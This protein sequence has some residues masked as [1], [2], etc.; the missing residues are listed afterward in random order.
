MKNKVKAWLW[1][2]P[3]ILILL[4][5]LIGGIIAKTKGLYPSDRAGSFVLFIVV[6]LLIIVCFFIGKYYDSKRDGFY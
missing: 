4:V 5:I 3:N 6:V 1:Q 2:I